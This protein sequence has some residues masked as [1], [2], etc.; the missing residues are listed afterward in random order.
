M[1]YKRIIKFLRFFY[2]FRKTK[3]DNF[4][5]DGF[6][7]CVICGK[8]TEIPATKPIDLRECY[9]AGCGQLCISCYQNLRNVN[10]KENQLLT[11]EQLS[12]LIEESRIKIKKR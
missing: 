7:R 1:K 9:E 4:V 8:Q 11:D 12:M 5:T 3:T 10:E 6:E 2:R